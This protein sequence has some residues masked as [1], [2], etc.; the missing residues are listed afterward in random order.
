MI[1]LLKTLLKLHCNSS[2]SILERMFNTWSDADDVQCWEEIE[3]WISPRVNGH[4]MISRYFL[5]HFLM[6]FTDRSRRE[7]CKIYDNA[8][9]DECAHAHAIPRRQ[10]SR[11]FSLFYVFPSHLRA[12]N[13][14]RQTVGLTTEIHN[15]TNMHAQL[16]LLSPI[17]SR[18]EWW[19]KK[20]IPFG[21]LWC[22]KTIKKHKI[23]CYFCFRCS[24]SLLASCEDFTLYS[25]QFY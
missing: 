3:N 9:F 8:I 14:S 7:M 1:F 23:L 13:V 12:S 5:L 24:C 2:S 10:H 16:Q 22:D 20:K 19:W 21:L 15:I 17:R 11:K 18:W 25:F 4:F 6:Q